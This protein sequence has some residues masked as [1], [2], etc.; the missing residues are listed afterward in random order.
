[1][2]QRTILK[3][4]KESTRHFPVTI[5]S[6]PRQV[7]KSTLIYTEMVK[8]GYSYV[9]LDKRSDLM[10]AVND[11]R[12]F[13]D[14]LS[15]PVII[16]ECQRAKELFVEIEAIVN[17]IRLEKGSSAANGMFILSGSSSKA[18]LEN[19]R[20]SMAGRCNIL[21]MSPL[22]FR[23]IIQKEEK[24]FIIDK[25]ESRKRAADY[26]LGEKELLD[27]IVKGCMPQLYDDS[28]VSR[29]QFFSSY[30]ETYMNKDLPE[31]LEIRNEKQ[32]NDFLTLLA[33]STGEELI[34]DNFARNTGVKAPTIK[35]WVS[36]L[37]KTG[38]IYLAR[39]YNEDSLVKQITKRPKVYFFDTGF[40]CYLAGI[41]DSMTLESSFLKGRMV[42]TW[43]ANE[44]RKSYTNNG[45]DQPIA[46]Y[47][48][49]RQHEIDLVILRDGRLMLVECKSGTGFNNSAVEAFACL[50]DTKYEKGTNA[51]ICTSLEPYSINEEVLVLPLSAI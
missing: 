21:K 45:S 24:P 20:E 42:E 38:I 15:Y 16:D 19:A 13:L 30:V 46:Y 48:D 4:I 25:I 12:S 43:I 44:I 7:G 47:R 9:T 28:D 17:R 49:S 8:E 31:V 5:V 32:F 11:P 33:S 26:S 41:R 37:E 23:E 36:A 40:A 22:S 2:L 35:Q 27:Y 39:P 14:R 29:E 34:Y 18:L 51:L 6:G 10:D 50:D 3:Q 1:M